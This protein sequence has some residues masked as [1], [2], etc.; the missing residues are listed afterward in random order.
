M[1][2]LPADLLPGGKKDRELTWS[3][4]FPEWCSF[5][6]ISDENTDVQDAVAEATAQME[7]AG[8]KIEKAVTECP[9]C[10]E[11]AA[12]EGEETAV[13]VPVEVQESANYNSEVQEQ[14]LPPLILTA[15]FID[16]LSAGVSVLVVS[17]F[18]LTTGLSSSFI[19]ILPHNLIACSLAAQGISGLVSLNNFLIGNCF[20]SGLFF[21]DIFWV[22]CT[23]VMVAVATQLEAPAKIILP[24]WGVIQQT[25]ERE[26]QKTMDDG[27]TQILKEL[28]HRRHPLI[29]LGDIV[30]PGLFLG[31]CL[32]FD[33]FLY[34]K[35][36][37]GGL[38]RSTDRDFH[39]ANHLFSKD[40][41]ALTSPAAWQRKWTFWVC[42]CAYLLSLI[43]TGW[44]MNFF[45]AAQPALLYICPALIIASVGSA[46]FG[47]NWTEMWS[48]D[49][50]SL[51][52]QES[53]EDLREAERRFEAEMDR[54]RGKGN[55]KKE[56][57][58]MNVLSKA[59]ESDGEGIEM[60]DVDTAG[61][62]AA[63]DGAEGAGGRGRASSKSRRVSMESKKSV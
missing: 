43:T 38:I 18:L 25:V 30:I 11:G 57:G 32:R 39:A 2:L 56:C 26:V 50:E 20:L 31:L 33:V 60:E 19:H 63:A 4:R 27:S 9:E 37:L 14:P 53:A 17:S 52:G 55:W 44:I 36:Q 7:A 23:P 51:M 46:W 5:L 42:F 41:S 59:V 62:G 1:R 58:Q 3:L 35:R 47:G 21:Y 54:T 48:Y 61:G 40:F 13:K 22:F 49:E 28:I 29:G 24:N 15:H 10:P 8:V 45:N 12:G 16:L 34:C 6:F